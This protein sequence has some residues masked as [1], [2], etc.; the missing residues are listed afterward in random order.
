MS[1]IS[2]KYKNTIIWLA[3]S[4]FTL[5]FSLVYELFSF[6]VISL[7]MILMFLYPL[8]LGAIPSYFLEKN[9][10]NGLHRLYVDGVIILTIRSLIYGI[11]EIY[12]T[13]TIYTKYYLLVGISL[14]IMGVIV[15]TI[16]NKLKESITLS[17][18]HI[19]SENKV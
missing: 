13:T 6:G 3:I 18:S 8:I 5:V 19:F 17:N 15:D 1:F 10:K 7:S 4:L 11:L 9:N 16:N 14:L 12:G 2:N